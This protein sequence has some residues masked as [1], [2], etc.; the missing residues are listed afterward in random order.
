MAPPT[1]LASTSSLLSYR[2]LVSSQPLCLPVHQVWGDCSVLATWSL[3]TRSLAL[4]RIIVIWRRGLPPQAWALSFSLAHLSEM[5]AAGSG[6]AWHVQSG[7]AGGL[8]AGC[9]PS[10]PTRAR[11][12]TACR[13]GSRLFVLLSHMIVRLHTFLS[14]TGVAILRHLR[15]PCIGCDAQWTMGRRPSSVPAI[16]PFLVQPDEATPNSYLHCSIRMPALLLA[17]SV[18]KLCRFWFSGVK[19]QLSCFLPVDAHSGAVFEFSDDFV[20]FTSCR[21]PSDIVHQGLTFESWDPLR[22]PLHEPW[23]ANFKHYRRQRWALR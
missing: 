9:L 4:P 15:S 7:Q 13:S 19:V 22:N 18:V 5:S 20:H 17:S 14:V 8:L 2:G 6:L 12:H 3:L 11:F 10:G 23:G 21:Q 16:S 1:G